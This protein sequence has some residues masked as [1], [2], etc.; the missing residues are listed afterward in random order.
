MHEWA[1]NLGPSEKFKCVLITI[2]TAPFGRHKHVD[3][4]LNR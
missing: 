2:P 3:I 4:L 1:S